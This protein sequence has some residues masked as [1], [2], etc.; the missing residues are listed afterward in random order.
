MSKVRTYVRAFLSFPHPITNY[1]RTRFRQVEQRP[2]HILSKRR[3]SRKR[4]I[5]IPPSII[6]Q[7]IAIVLGPTQR[8]TFVGK[9]L[10]RGRGQQIG[11]VREGAIEW[12]G[13]GYALV[14]MHQ[15]GV[16]S[17]PKLSSTIPL[18]NPC[19]LFTGLHCPVPKS[20]MTWLG[21]TLI[22]AM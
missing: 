9:D 14:H 13:M 18:Q 2:S 6:L 22:C 19:T 7:Y 5:I 17:W 15:G 21:R 16:A 20:D 4:T 11:E 3:N 12:H 8:N 10:S 1:S